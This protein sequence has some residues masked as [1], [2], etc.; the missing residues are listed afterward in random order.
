MSSMKNAPAAAV[1][2]LSCKPASVCVYVVNAG[3][4]RTSPYVIYAW[5]REYNDGEG[6]YDYQNAYVTLHDAVDEASRIF[7]VTIRDRF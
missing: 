2:V 5:D 7:A 4:N 3:P 6:H 1:A